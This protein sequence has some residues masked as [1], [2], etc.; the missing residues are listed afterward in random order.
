MTT[1]EM[2]LLVAL[3]CAG[4]LMRTDCGPPEAKEVPPR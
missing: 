4:I 3:E 2:I 1:L